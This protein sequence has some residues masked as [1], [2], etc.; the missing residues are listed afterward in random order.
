M[1]L[2]WSISRSPFSQPARS[3][4]GGIDFSLVPP[5]GCGDSELYN[6][7]VHVHRRVHDNGESADGIM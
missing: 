7:Y 2:L 1:V 6:M 5:C 4:F 3:A